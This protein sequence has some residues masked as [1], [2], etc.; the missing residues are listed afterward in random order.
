MILAPGTRYHPLG[1]GELLTDEKVMISAVAHVF[2]TDDL[3]A[4]R[5]R[6]PR[7]RGRAFASCGVEFS[8]EAVGA[9]AAFRSRDLIRPV[10]LV[11]SV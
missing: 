3:K 10:D 1:Q 2:E 4:R 6:L 5:Q 9:T 8:E 7:A 11:D